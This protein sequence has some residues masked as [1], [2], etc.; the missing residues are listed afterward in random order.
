MN[1]IL[2]KNIF[3]AVNDKSK[4]NPI[5]SVLDKDKVQFIGTNGT[6]KYLN[7][8]G[9]KAKSVVKGFDFDGRV[10]SINKNVFAGILADRLKKS[11][12]LELKKLKVTPINLVIVDLYKLNAKKFPESM[13]I[14]GQ[15]LIRAAVKNYKNVAV[16][17]DANSLKSLIR[18]LAKNNNSTELTYRKKQAILAAKFIAER[19]TLEAAILK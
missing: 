2:I 15:A 7:V 18:E 8:K 10:K 9:Y 17:F 14:G 19:G 5:L 3:A 1:K 11:H 4:I 12:T 16:A 13:D 6:V